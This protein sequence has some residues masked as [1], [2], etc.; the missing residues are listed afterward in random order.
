[1]KKFIALCLAIVMTLSLVSFSAIAADVSN[2]DVVISADEVKETYEEGKTISVPVNI[3]A[4]TGLAVG[5][6]TVEWDET[7]MQLSSVTYGTGLGQNNGSPME[8]PKVDGEETEGIENDGSY[9]ISFGS[10]LAETDFETTGLLFTLNFVVLAE[11][12]AGSY[13]IT[14]S[15][16]K[17]AFLDAEMKEKT[18]SFSN[19]KVTLYYEISKAALSFDA[20][21]KGKTPATNV[22]VDGN[23]SASNITWTDNAGNPVGET[24]AANTVYKATITLTALT[25]CEF[26]EE[27]TVEAIAGSTVAVERQS[28]TQ[29]VVT[30]TFPSTEGKLAQTI[31]AENITVTYG[32]AEQNWTPTS[33][34]D[35]VISYEITAGSDVISIEDGKISFEKAGNA[36]IKISATETND[37]LA[38]EKTIN[39]TVAAAGYT[40]EMAATKQYIEAGDGLNAITVD[41]ETGNGVNDESVSGT[42]KWYTDAEMTTEATDA[43]LTAS[44]TL[45]WAFTATDANYVDTAITGSLEIIVVSEGDI[46]G[47]GKVSD[48]DAMILVRYVNNWSDYATKIV[49]MGVADIND[50]GAVTEADAMYLARHLAGWKN[51]SSL[52]SASERN[53]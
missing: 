9:P 28:E 36:T 34:G 29:A 46:N 32:D 21:E 6:V 7:V 5:R 38:A 20:P 37:Y 49:N 47:D 4:N 25:G 23:V 17:D 45:Y 22:T 44:T 41:P 16:D 48:V 24:F 40:Y 43:D 35:G 19:G 8:G 26:A 39:V 30:F 14:L 18:P 11:A 13:D 42:L 52:E 51:Y 2:A 33:N 12:A 1:M 31:T 10:Y 50:D 53:A 15:G 3:T 27:F